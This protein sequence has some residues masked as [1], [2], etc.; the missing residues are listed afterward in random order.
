MR[1]GNRSEVLFLTQR[2]ETTQRIK[3]RG[4]DL[5]LIYEDL[6]HELIGCFFD[7]HNSL[8]VGYDER[9]Y[10]KALERR[11]QRKGI[12]H[13]SKECKALFHRDCKVRK[14]EED[15]ITHGKIILELKT[16]KSGFIRANYV[17]I[18]SELKLWGMRLGL[19]V[20]FGLQKVEI[21]RIPFT[22]KKLLMKIMTTLKVP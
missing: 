8:G 12:H 6:T 5:E 10:H 13:R 21:E 18:I 3:I 19:L 22:E 9:S 20:N 2:I 7:V 14:F 16:R 4:T 15:F 17:Q 11:L 1:G